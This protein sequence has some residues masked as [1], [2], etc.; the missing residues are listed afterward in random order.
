MNEAELKMRDIL[1]DARNKGASEIHMAVNMPVVLRMSD[2][3]LERQP[4]DVFNLERLEALT[5]SL[6]NAAQQD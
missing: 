5:M 3:R 2:G 1:I 4:A 6:L